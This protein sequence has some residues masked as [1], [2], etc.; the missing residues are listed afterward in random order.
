MSL[1]LGLVGALVAGASV[2]MDG[3]ASAD[4]APQ[5]NDIVGVGGDTPQYAASFLAD[6]DYGGHAGYNGAGNNYRLVTFNATADG[7]GRS[8]YAN[9]STLSSPIPLNPTVTLRAGTYPVQRI[10][11]SG[12]ALSA[13]VGDTS[14]E[15]NFIASSSLPTPAQQTAA[16]NAGWGYLHVVEFGT[17]TVEIAADTTNNIPAGGL[18]GAELVGIYSGAYTKWNQ[19]PNNSGGSNAAIIPLIPPSSSAV[20]KTFV[21]DLQ[22]YNG[23]TQVTL[24]ASVK[25]VEQNDPTAITGSSSP[26]DTIVPFSQARWNLWQDGYFHNPATAYQS[27]PGVLTYAIKLLSGTAGDGNAAYTSPITDYIIFRQSDT[28]DAPWQP[29]GTRNWVQTLFSSPLGNNPW[30]ESSAGQTLITASGV[31]PDYVDLGDVHS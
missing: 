31:T 22:S 14:K 16:S 6:G 23:N 1:K 11:S 25:T 20:Y 28:T 10:S 15:I 8:A 21:A 12:N 5:P 17:D 24:A 27:S 26:A 30:I 13:L 18:S 29:G 19:L 2:L 7:N 4:Y 3:A 9:G